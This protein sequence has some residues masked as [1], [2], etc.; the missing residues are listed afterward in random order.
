VQELDRSSLGL[1]D[2]GEAPSTRRS[3]RWSWR[4]LH[5]CG[6]ARRLQRRDGLGPHRQG[7]GRPHRAEQVR[8]HAAPKGAHRGSCADGTSR[9]RRSSWAKEPVLVFDDYDIEQAVTTPFRRVRR[10]GQ[11]CICAAGIWC[12][13]AFYRNSSS[14][15]PPSRRR[16]DRRSG[17]SKTQLGR[18]SGEAA[19]PRALLCRG[20][21]SEG[22]RS[23][24]GRIRTSTTGTR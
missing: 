4:A 3:P 15:S 16:S 18:S 8:A 6:S 11:T 9:V 14:G 13:A 23:S 12:S 2:G 7:A 17:R 5:R 22:P 10:R 19:P 1:H 20:G 21:L 24:P